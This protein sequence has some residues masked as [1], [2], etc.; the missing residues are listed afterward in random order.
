MFDER[1]PTEQDREF[2][3]R[4]MNEGLE[5]MYDKDMLVYHIPLSFKDVVKKQFKYGIGS[6]KWRKK[7]FFN[8]YLKEYFLDNVEDFLRGKTRFDL[9]LFTLMNNTLYQAGRIYGSFKKD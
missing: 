1:L 6:V 2:G 9:M 4:I 5:L 7:S 3:S 8:Y